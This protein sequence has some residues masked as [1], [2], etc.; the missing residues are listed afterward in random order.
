MADNDMQDNVVQLPAVRRGTVVQ[1]FFSERRIGWGDFALLETDF[2]DFEQF[3]LAV[4]RNDLICCMELRTVAGEERG[5]RLVT[6]RYPVA[7][8]GSEIQRARL[9]WWKLYEMEP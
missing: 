7:F 3:L 2:E 9:P 8:R 4:D 5:S 1:A 6:N